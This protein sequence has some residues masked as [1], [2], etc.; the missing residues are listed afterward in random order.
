MQLF[1]ISKK[2]KIM[3]QQ[4]FD[5][6]VKNH[7]NW[8]KTITL[9]RKDYERYVISGKTDSRWD[10]P[11]KFVKGLCNY[12][13]STRKRKLKHNQNACDI[14]RVIEK[15]GI[16]KPN[17]SAYWFPCAWDWGVDNIVK[18]CIMPRLKILRRAEKRLIE[19]I[20]IYESNPNVNAYT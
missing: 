7:K 1:Q 12:Y 8:L 16:K 9:A 6:R 10:V 18:E 3:T 2:L 14:T 19:L 15:I 5:K 20:E 13:A 11:M 17:R 4:E